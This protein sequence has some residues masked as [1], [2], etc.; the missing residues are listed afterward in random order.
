MLRN[1]IIVNDTSYVNGG[2]SQVA[3]TSALA[4]ARHGFDV[5]MF[6]ASKPVAPELR[7]SP[8]RVVSTGQ[9]EILT[10]PNRL[11]AALQG[12]WNFKAARLML[13]LLRGL[14]PSQTVVHVHSWSKALSS[15]PVRVALTQ[16][17]RVICTM[18][19]Y[20]LACPN[21]GFFSYPSSLVCHRTPLSF[22]CLV[23]NCDVRSYPQKIWRVGR[24]IAQRYAGLLPDGLRNFI[25]VSDFGKRVLQPFLPLRAHIHRIDN[26]VD[27][28]KAPPADT[29]NNDAFVFV[30]TLAEHKG[31]LL[32]AAA[33]L[34]AG[35]RIVFVGSGPLEERISRFYPSALITGW[36]PRNETI[37]AIRQARALVLPSLSYENQPLVVAEAAAVG[38]PAI[39]SD[40]SAARDMVEDG[41]TGLWFKGGDRDDLA[42]KMRRLQDPR[43]AAAMGSAAYHRYWSRP[44]SM[45]NH[46]KELIGV[47]AHVL[48]AGG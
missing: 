23:E 48:G 31:P 9:H 3:L 37:K 41:V 12:I 40:R 7:F 19:D 30:G 14:D 47:Y 11:R 26:P 8:L 10:D 43:S 42:E 2:A 39:V 46:L 24:H 32:L 21:G 15:A 34:R 38:V 33:A 18:H 28:L 1:V 5:T 20:F 25:A 13:G 6:S 29:G 22:S 16:G 27:V 17:Y 35:A 44:S 45:E 4:L 36:L